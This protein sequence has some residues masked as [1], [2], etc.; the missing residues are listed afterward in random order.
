MSELNKTEVIESITKFLDTHSLHPEKDL[1][2]PKCGSSLDWI[3]G[4]FW[5][6]HTDLEWTIPMPYC[7][8]CEPELPK[9]VN[10]PLSAV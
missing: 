1:Q 4:R 10:L 7:R 8:A 9:A 3:K 2:C 5:L 6:A